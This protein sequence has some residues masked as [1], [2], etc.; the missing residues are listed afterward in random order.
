MAL[1]NTCRSDCFLAR[2][3]SRASNFSFLASN[4]SMTRP[5]S[6]ASMPL[7][8]SNCDNSS[9]SKHHTPLQQ[10]AYKQNRRIQTQSASNKQSNTIQNTARNNRNQMTGKTINKTHYYLR[11]A[12]VLVSFKVSRRSARAALRARM[13]H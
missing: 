5:G 13:T 3:S 1:V 7:D 12:K 2:S 9:N 8:I 11:F 10:P 4:G 6:S